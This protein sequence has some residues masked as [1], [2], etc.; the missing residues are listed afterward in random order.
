M[1]S[2]TEARW[3]RHWS[4]R[5]DLPLPIL[6]LFASL[7]GLVSC[8]SPQWDERYQTALAGIAPE[9]QRYSVETDRYRVYS[10][11]DPGRIALVAEVIEQAAD[12]YDELLGIDPDQSKQSSVYLHGE[13][14]H[15]NRIVESLGFSPSI[16]AFYSPISPSAIHLLSAETPDNELIPLLLHE[17]LHQRA[18]LHFCIALDCT[19]SEIK[20]PSMTPLSYLGLP[21]WLNEGLA[22]FMESARYTARDTN[23]RLVTG[24][25]NRDRLRQLQGMIEGNYRFSLSRILERPYGE[26]F[27]S[28]DY[29]LAWGI[30]YDMIRHGDGNGTLLNGYLRALER[31]LARE[32]RR[33]CNGD[34]SERGKPDE[35][36]HIW[37]VLLAQQSLQTFKEVVTAEGQ[38]IAQWEGQWRQRMLEIESVP[39][40]K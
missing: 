21:L 17:G 33:L 30:V 3:K 23:G 9:M 15:Y 11:T 29:A 34:R 28:G 37:N 38:T 18:D 12:A 20:G 8:A 6:L 13:R 10:D 16:R 25:P 39:S 22:T 24:E 26:A 31:N 14:R 7:F 19:G 5:F 2:G 36:F 40:K 1:A 4:G 35:S 32:G 27:S